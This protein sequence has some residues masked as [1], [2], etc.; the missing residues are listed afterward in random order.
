MIIAFY[1]FRGILKKKI[2]VEANRKQ[3]AVDDGSVAFRYRLQQITTQACGNIA[4]SLG[5]ERNAA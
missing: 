5:K 4:R 1:W 3:I 2:N